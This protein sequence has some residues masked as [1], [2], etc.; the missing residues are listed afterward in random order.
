M[1]QQVLKICRFYEKQSPLLNSYEIEMFKLTVQAPTKSKIPALNQKI[2]EPSESTAAI[3][4][5]PK[6]SSERKN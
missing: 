2:T 1:R 5:F 4:E 6:T 3:T